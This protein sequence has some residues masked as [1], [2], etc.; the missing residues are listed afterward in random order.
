MNQKR[1]FPVL[2]I[3]VA[4]LSVVFL[5][6]QG[7]FGNYALAASND[8]SGSWVVN[9]LPDPATGVPPFTNLSS[10]TKDGLVVSSNQVGLASIGVWEKASDHT[11]HASFQG[12]EENNGQL[13]RY[14]VRSTIEFSDNKEQF[15]GPFITDIF[16]LDGNPLFSISGTV[17]ADRLHV[18]LIE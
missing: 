17:S 5:V 6:S 9:I 15:S 18:E 11:F 3:W 2:V 16:D 8:V 1:W 12:Y 13:V 7:M 4:I 10:F 14:L